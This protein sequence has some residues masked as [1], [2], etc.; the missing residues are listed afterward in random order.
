MNKVIILTLIISISTLCFAD[1]LTQEKREDILYLLERSGS[2]DVGLELATNITQ[3]FNQVLS[4]TNK[5]IPKNVFVVL[6]EELEIL[7]KEETGKN[8][9]LTDISINVYHDHF[10]HDE[11][12]QLNKFY[13]SPIGQKLAARTPTIARESMIASQK[14]AENMQPLLVDRALTVLRSQGYNFE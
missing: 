10:T 2:L 8:G 14:W 11:I 4:Q 1:E 9:G 6:Q 12:K 7:L 3:Q 13:D 5:D